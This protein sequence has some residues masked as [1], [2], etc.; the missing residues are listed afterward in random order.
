MNNI[1][2]LLV[3]ILF[4]FSIVFQSFAIDS[5]NNLKLDSVNDNSINVS[6][7]SVSEAIM[8][9]VYFSENSWIE[10]GYTNQTDLIEATS[11]EVPNLES[12]K[13]YYLSVVSLDENWEESDYSNEIVV[14]I[15]SKS[16][17]VDF[18]LEWVE[19]I[20]TKNIELNFTNLLDNSTDTVREFKVVNKKDELDVFE[21]EKNELNID[22]N[23]KLLLTMDREFQVWNEYEVIVIWIMDENTNIIES[24]IDNIET[25]T[26]TEQTKMYQEKNN[27]EENL[28]SA[29]E[30]NKW[31]TWTNLTSEEVENTTESVAKNQSNL[32]ETW[33]EHILIVILSIVLWGL[34]FVL[35]YKKA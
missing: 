19:V 24:W 29:T 21:V 6:W 2:R 26:V 16:A 12:W 9:Y 8:Y 17:S 15:E 25:F 14:D 11:A 3:S 20:D 32:P 7:D 4:S 30:E 18:A 35:K 27:I 13:T 23:S 28:N 5:P 31:P 22:D 33:P 1:L 34:F 10:N